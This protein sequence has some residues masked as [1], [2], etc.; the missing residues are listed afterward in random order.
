MASIEVFNLYVMGGGYPPGLNTETQPT[1]IKADETPDGYGFD[2]TI[3]GGIKKGIIPSGTTRIA[4]TVTLTS[5]PYYWYYNRLWNITN[6]TA[7]TASTI[8]TYG[9]LDYDD[10]YVPQRLGKL[11]FSEDANN[12]LA[13]VPFGRDNLYVGKSTGGYILSNIADSRALFQKTDIMQEL[14]ISAAANVVELD[15]VIYVSNASGL[16]ASTGNET[17]EVFRKIRSSSVVGTGVAL[18]ADYAKKRIVGAATF[19]YEPET[20]KVFKYSSTAFRYT[21]RQFRLPAYDPFSIER[22]WFVIKRTDSND[23]WLTYQLK[24]EDEDWT[25]AVTRNFEFISDKY[26]YVSEDFE[27]ARSARKFQLRITDMSS[28][29]VLKEIRLDA[30]AFNAD[31]YS[32]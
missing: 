24:Y 22:V 16:F 7:S 14:A 31:D 28:N 15:G 29:L 27:Q 30:G 6:R 1:D 8:L 19:V 23:V 3:D 25:D 5:V 26:T 11:H 18:T 13:I 2:L 20:D 32:T 17:K 9:A 4:K 10:I 21:T 12:I